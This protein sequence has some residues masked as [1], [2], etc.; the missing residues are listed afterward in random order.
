M[1]IL[2]QAFRKREREIN[3]LH[4]SIVIVIAYEMRP[5]HQNAV[6]GDNIFIRE[7]EICTTITWIFNGY[8]VQVQNQKLDKSYSID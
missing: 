4:S 6:F 3:V 7:K 8:L 2:S 5:F 1:D